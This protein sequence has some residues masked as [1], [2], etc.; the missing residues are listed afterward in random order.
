MTNIM[1]GAIGINLR[2]ETGVDLTGYNSALIKV[3]NPDG[4]TSSWT[5]DSVDEENGYLYYET[6]DG[7]FDDDGQYIFQS[8]VT[9]TDGEKR[10]GY[11][12]RL[13][14]Y[15]NRVSLS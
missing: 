2:V 9:F 4:T 15:E 14:I 13:E 10:I 8:Y 11:P 1:A 5:P 6:V 7:D 3:L 12:A